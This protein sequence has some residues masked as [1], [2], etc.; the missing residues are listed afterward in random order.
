MEDTE[1]WKDV[2]GYDGCYMISNLGRVKSTDR[3]VFSNI[4]PGKKR[5]ISGKVLTPSKNIWGYH[6]VH[7]CKNGKSKH[8]TIH[9][10]VYTTF[11]GDIPDG[12][13]IN[14]I[15]EDKTDNRLQNLKAVTKSENIN[16]GKRNYNVGKKLSRRVVQSLPDGTDLTVWFSIQSASKELNIKDSNISMCCKGKRKTAGG[17]KW[18]Y[19]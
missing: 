13:E 17:Y 11:I 8:H 12:K 10:L 1:I 6:E 19:A 16:W 9:K 14:H 2:P 15:N 18:C 4:L 5:F 3:Y 7:L